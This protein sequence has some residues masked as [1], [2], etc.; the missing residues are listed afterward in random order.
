MRISSL[1]GYYSGWKFKTPTY[2]LQFFAKKKNPSLLQAAESLR[3][4][5]SWARHQQDSSWRDDIY[6]MKSLFLQEMNALGFLKSVEMVRQDIKCNRCNKGVQTSY[7]A[8]G[9]VADQSA[10]WHCNGT[11]V[12]KKVLLYAFTVKIDGK[13]FVWHQLADR[14]KW[15]H[16]DRW[17]PIEYDDAGNPCVDLDAL[18]KFRE[19]KGDAPKLSA[20]QF[21]KHL[22]TLAVFVTR[23]IAFE[24][25][26]L[27]GLASTLRWD[28]SEL[29]RRAGRW[30][31]DRVGWRVIQAL[32]R[33]G[34]I[35]D[36]LPF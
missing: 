17:Y 23:N 21:Q 36:S 24:K 18:P 29:K 20:W 1:D 7:Y 31:D 34:L 33:A 2:I 35:E 28:V 8:D 5:N 32:K 30:L 13:E 11:G 14:A 15:A 27:D 26:E 12:Y 4:L 16:V 25:L 6:E 9:N 22:M 10:C 19:P 3:T